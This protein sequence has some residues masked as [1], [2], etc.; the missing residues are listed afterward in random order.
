MSNLMKNT[1]LRKTS[2]LLALFMFLLSTAA[3]AQL[4]IGIVNTNEV[5]NNLPERQ[6]I[7]QQLNTFIQQK[8]EEF[9]QSTTEFQNAVAQ[10]Q[11]NQSEMT[12]QQQ[13][14]RE[15]ELSQMEQNL[16]QMQQTVQQEVAQKRQELLGP[17]FNR[18]D[19]A[20][21]AVAEANSLDYVLNET[22]GNGESIVAYTDEAT[23]DL[24]QQVI[25][26]V[27]SQSP[28]NSQNQN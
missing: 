22:T 21:Q 1:M 13:E 7:Q 11:Q 12:Q 23:T 5:L 3:F 18:I 26:Q 17:I 15:K 28:Q 6:E 20:I 4:D 2:G 16:T 9:Q 25:D 10:Y 24:T 19:Q 27:N 14:Q 8:Q